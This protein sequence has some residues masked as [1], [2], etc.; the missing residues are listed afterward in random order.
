MIIFLYI[1][2]FAFAADAIFLIL[3]LPTY[4]I[5]KFHRNI[6]RAILGLKKKIHKTRKDKLFIQPAE[7]F[8]RIFDSFFGPEIISKISVKKTFYLSFFANIFWLF[9]ILIDNANTSD[10][11]SWSTYSAIS[12][13]IIIFAAC[14]FFGDFISI[15]ITRKIMKKI[16][17]THKIKYLVWD[18]LGAISGY[19]L[20]ISINILIIFLFDMLDVPDERWFDFGIIGGFVAGWTLTI[21]I[22]SGKLIISIFGILAIFTITIPTFIYWVL[23]LLTNLLFTQRVRVLTLKTLN[24]IVIFA[25]KTIL[26]LDPKTKEN[27]HEKLWSYITGGSKALVGLGGLLATV[28]AYLKFV[29]QVH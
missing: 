26:F 25:Q 9:L 14:N 7:F 18:L 3:S 29:K 6:R 23:L 17:E 28:A 2:L 16:L 27:I 1:F 10:R 22:T 4:V 19:I 15:S 5:V 13:N 20:T 8:N 21:L 12:L 11:I 24:K